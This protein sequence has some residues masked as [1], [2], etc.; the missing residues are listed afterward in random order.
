MTSLQQQ[1]LLVSQLPVQ[2]PQQQQQQSA[3]VRIKAQLKNL[4]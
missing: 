3:L 1:L 2:T 4:W